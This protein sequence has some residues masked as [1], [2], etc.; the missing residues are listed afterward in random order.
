[1]LQVFAVGFDAARPG[2]RRG[3]LPGVLPRLQGTFR[4]PRT[5]TVCTHPEREGIE[6]A[7]IAGA[8]FRDIARQFRVSKDAVARHKAEHLGKLLAEAEAARADS[9]LE[10]LQTLEAEAA[11][12]G[13][14]AER[15]KD[16]RG[17]LLSVRERARLLELLMRKTE[18]AELERRLEELEEL[19]RSKRDWRR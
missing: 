7:L 16:Y 17:A 12:L 11:R 6:Q 1:M 2:R 13:K 18:G 9:L 8:A 19:A 14:L 3:V 4:M 15:S 10:K 5:C